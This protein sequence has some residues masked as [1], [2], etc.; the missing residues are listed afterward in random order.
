MPKA[1]AAGIGGGFRGVTNAVAG[2]LPP[3]APSIAPV[4]RIDPAARVGSPELARVA[5]NQGWRLIIAQ[6]AVAATLL[7]QCHRPMGD[8]VGGYARRGRAA[9]AC[10][11]QRTILVPERALA[12]GRG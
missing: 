11:V 4:L 6:E 8:F 10:A 12:A 2:G 3:V 7:R 9:A 1:A 5:G